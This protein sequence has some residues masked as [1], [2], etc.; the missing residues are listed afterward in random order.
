MGSSLHRKVRLL[1]AYVVYSFDQR[2]VDFNNS[3]VFALHHFEHFE[4]YIVV[5]A[6]ARILFELHKRRLLLLRVLCR[7]WRINLV[8]RLFGRLPS[9][10]SLASMRLFLD[11]EGDGTALDDIEELREDGHQLD[12]RVHFLALLVEHED[13][14][15]SNQRC[16]S[17]NTTEQY[18]YAL[19][20]FMLG[21]LL[22]FEFHENVGVDE[23]V[24]VVILFAFRKVSARQDLAQM[25]VFLFFVNI[26]HLVVGFRIFIQLIMDHLYIFVLIHS[27]RNLPFVFTG[28]FHI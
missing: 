8:L 3:S 5:I 1:R 10:V 13:A 18:I 28:H 6:E 23:L 14:F 27:S 4:L 26:G 25:L 2:P 16:R 20:A 22:E 7:K 9:P 19:P 12:L 24:L 15:V 11:V 17:G 21:D